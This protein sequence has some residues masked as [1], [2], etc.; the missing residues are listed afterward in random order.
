MAEFVADIRVVIEVV[1]VAGAMLTEVLVEV[2]EAAGEHFE[3]VAE[4]VL[5]VI[6][7]EAHTRGSQ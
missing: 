4:A 6:V 7:E 3:G 5:A 1:V 2:V